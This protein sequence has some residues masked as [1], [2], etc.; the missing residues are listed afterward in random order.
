MNTPTF[1]WQLKAT[2]EHSPLG[3][4]VNTALAQTS[5]QFCEA[6]SE[7]KEAPNSIVSF[8]TGYTLWWSTEHHLNEIHR[9][10]KSGAGEI[11]SSHGPLPILFFARLKQRIRE[12]SGSD[13]LLMRFC[14]E[15]GN[16]VSVESW[17]N[18]KSELIRM[19]FENQILDDVYEH[20]K[21][22]GFVQRLFDESCCAEAEFGYF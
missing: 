20:A 13:P 4:V 21:S 18:L 5:A 19:G 12:L 1:H 9:K 6:F 10:E 8:T 2:V 7:V 3:D 14:D 15:D 17:K 11:V 16:S 22:I